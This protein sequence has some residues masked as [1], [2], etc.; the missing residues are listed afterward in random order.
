MRAPFLAL[1]LAP[2]LLAQAPSPAPMPPVRLKQVQLSPAASVSQT[3][4]ITTLKI[5]Y[6][7][8]AVRGRAIWGEVVPFDAVW[9]AGANEATVFTFSDP[10]KIN[11]KDLP[12]GS[13]GFFVLPG[14]DSWTLIL[15]RKA[16]QWGAYEYKAEEDALRF[17]VKPQT[18]GHQEY[19]QYDL[20]VASPTRLRVDLRWEKKVAGFDVDIDVPGLYWKHLEE[21]LAKAPAT[22]WVPWYQAAN[23]CFQQKLHPEKAMGW[24]DASLKAQETYRN[25]E[26]KARL[27]DAAGQRPQ[28][29]P[30]L[31]KAI[32]AATAAKTPKAYL[33]GL[34]KTRQE[35]QPKAK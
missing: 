28:A 19:L 22:D 12:A 15:N 2:A 35:W 14:K 1:F 30:I 6:F 20:Q 27:L 16:K 21:S 26:L 10:V 7:R 8:P 3:L 29:L 34:E 33:D 11:G 31:D 5:D 25:L 32:A 24:I 4:G 18:S 23:Y 13:Y 17:E 9:R